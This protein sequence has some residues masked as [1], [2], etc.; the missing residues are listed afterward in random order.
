MQERRR[1]VRLDTRLVVS[2]AIVPPTAAQES[3]TKDIGGG[4]VCLFVNEPLKPGT[5]LQIDLTLPGRERPIRFLGEVVWCESYEV[6]GATQRARSIE[7]GVKFLQI[8]P[9]DQ[10]TIMQHVILSLQPHQAA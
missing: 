3:V 1:F 10:Q 9:A 2:Y 4:G 6:I 8:N 7:A 5:R